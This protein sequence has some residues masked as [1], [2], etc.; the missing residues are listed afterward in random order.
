[1]TSESSVFITAQIRVLTFIFVI[2]A[3]CFTIFEWRFQIEADNK[4]EQDLS[5][6]GFDWT[7]CKIKTYLNL[8]DPGICP[9][10]VNPARVDYP[11]TAFESFLLSGIGVLIFIAFGSDVAIYRHWRI[12]GEHAK[13]KN[14]TLLKDLII[15]GKVKSSTSAG[16]ASGTTANSSGGGSSGSGSHR[17][18]ARSASTHSVGLQ[19]TEENL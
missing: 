1:V 13:M 15:Y 9:G 18:S 19:D 16:G 5:S 3:I 11:H 2:F 7:I 4:Q 12:I 17:V 8:K 6:V 14:W 10:D